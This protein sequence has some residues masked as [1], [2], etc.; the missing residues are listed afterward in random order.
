[1]AV[2][3]A[4][5]RKRNSACHQRRY[6][7]DAAY[8]RQKLAQQSAYRQ[9]NCDTTRARVRACH[10]VAK[11]GINEEDYA[12]LL[13]QQCGVCRICK[14]AETHKIKGKIVRLAVDHNEATG[15]IRGLLC[16]ACNTSLGKFKH[17]PA[18]LRAAATYLIETD[19][20]IAAQF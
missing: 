10:L 14:C 8:R 4:V 1:M 5:I 15:T 13:A 11:Y 3:V 16:F 12:R 19:P 18:L 20:V 6:H 2:S 17:D 7:T 9:A